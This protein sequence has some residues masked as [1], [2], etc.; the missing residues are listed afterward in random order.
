[1]CISAGVSGIGI[2]LQALRD[3]SP[4]PMRIYMMAMDTLCPPPSIFTSV[5]L[6]PSGPELVM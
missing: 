6:S 5:G 2:Y 4:C 1:M 3:V